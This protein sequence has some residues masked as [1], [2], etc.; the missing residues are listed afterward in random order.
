MNPRIRYTTYKLTPHAMIPI[1]D[2]QRNRRNRSG[3][4][5]VFRTPFDGPAVRL[6]LGRFSAW[7]RHRSAGRAAAAVPFHQATRSDFSPTVGRASARRSPPNMLRGAVGLKPDPQFRASARQ[8]TPPMPPPIGKANCRPRPNPP[9]HPQMS[10]FVGICRN[11]CL[12]VPQ[13]FPDN[14]ASP[15][16]PPRHPIASSRGLIDA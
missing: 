2:A 14:A 15:Q 12:F 11:S 13:L 8:D 1:A 4:P 7:R 10:E 5:R 16:A 9:K 3:S 6:P